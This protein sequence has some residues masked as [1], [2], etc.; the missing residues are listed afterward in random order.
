MAKND[1]KLEA[2]LKLGMTRE[3]AWQVIAD[4]D[5][6]DHGAAKDFDLTKEQLKVAKKY[7]GTGTRKAPTNAKRTRKENPLKREIIQK[8]FK[9]IQE[10]SNAE[11]TNPERMI[12]FSAEDENFEI[13]LT[14]KRKP[15]GD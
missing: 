8:I 14:Q 15:K 9:A 3:E 13:T 7:T 12:A 6:I 10:Y 5:D 1:A 11:I 2:L 4:D